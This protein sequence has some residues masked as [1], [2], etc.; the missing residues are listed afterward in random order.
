MN[1][2][3]VL[4]SEN[5]VP[6]REYVFHVLF[7]E[8]LKWEY[9]LILDPYERNYE[10]TIDNKKIEIQD[11]FFNSH[12]LPLS[13]LNIKN[14]PPKTGELISP[15][16][17][18]KYPIL[19]G[20]N[21]FRIDENRIYLGLDIFGSVFFMITR[22]EEYLITKKNLYGKVDE[23][24][25]WALKN[26]IHN[27]PIVNEYAELLRY[28][29]SLLGVQ[30]PECDGNF[31]IK[32]TH[33]VDWVYLSD[34]ITLFRN[35]IKRFFKKGQKKKSLDILLKYYYYRINGINPF[36]PFDEIMD[37]ANKYNLETSFYFKAVIEN[38]QGLTYDIRDNRVKSII[39]NIEDR[40]YEV[41]FHPSENT[42]SNDNQFKIEANRLRGIM[43]GLPLGGRNHGL[44]YNQKTYL[45]WEQNGFKYDSGV[46]FQFH[47][48]FRSGVCSEFTLFDIFTRRKLKLKE[49]P[50]VL[51]DTVVLRNKKSPEEFFDEAKRIIEEVYYHKG[52]VSFNWH[53][54]LVNS[55]E[56]KNYKPTYFKIID[57]LGELICDGLK[58]G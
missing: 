9:D 39:N 36:D 3:R 43:S 34:Q 54:N 41:G 47:N 56:F 38:E 46:G 21:N 53:S 10:I 44:Y 27:K 25:F 40:G 24:E 58:T 35:L 23:T 2:L 57:Y 11:S 1:R 42:V 31:R 18:K 29:F 51:M 7:K 17:K 4:C 32:L 5:N 55:I 15:V 48:G 33:D 49:L 26:G 50:F 52:Y 45:Q 12:I 16:L 30:L 13:Y 28:L 37:A 22:W 8:I 19:Y 6:E 14:I 20:E